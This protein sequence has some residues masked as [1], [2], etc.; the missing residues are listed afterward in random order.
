MRKGKRAEIGRNK[1]GRRTPQSSLS[2]TVSRVTR[3]CCQCHRRTHPAT[4]WVSWGA[5]RR[6]CVVAAS[7]PQERSIVERRLA[8]GWLL[9]VGFPFSR[10]RSTNFVVRLVGL[11]LLGFP[12]RVFYFVVREETGEGVDVRRLLVSHTYSPTIYSTHA[13]PAQKRE[14]KKKKTHETLLTTLNQPP[15]L[16]AHHIP[17]RT[18]LKITHRLLTHYLPMD[19]S[20]PPIQPTE[21]VRLHLQVL[22]HLAHLA[23]LLLRV[24]CLTVDSATA[25]FEVF[26]GFFGGLG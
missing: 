26:K 10:G 20:N 23:K 19:H 14:R 5:W 22:M 13:Q 6:I 21:Q 9:R 16:K 12:K 17:N 4:P 25:T 15:K 7:T 3:C 11:F 8:L 1:G 24:I 18:P 2:E